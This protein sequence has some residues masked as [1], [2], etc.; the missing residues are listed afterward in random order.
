M[1]K[2]KI[3][4]LR[5]DRNL[6]QEDVAVAVEITKPTYIKYEK[7][8]QSPQLATI[9]KLAKFYGVTA[10]ELIS[11]VQPD[12]DEKLITK[13]NLI[14]QLE[15]NEKDSIILVIEGIIFRHQSMS[16]NKKFA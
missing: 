4:Q 10:Q 16:L 5:K 1:F 3:K 8:T 9:E 6:N 7:G 11:D 13:L 14:K 2:D 12:L 15:D